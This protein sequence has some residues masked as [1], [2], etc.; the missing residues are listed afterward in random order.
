MSRCGN[1]GNSCK[2]KALQKDA[3]PNYRWCILT[4]E[5]IIMNNDDDGDDDDDDDDDYYYYYYNLLLSK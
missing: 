5:L 1:T 3:F 2:R 4:R